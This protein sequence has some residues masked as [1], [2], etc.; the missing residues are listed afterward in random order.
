M[1]LPRRMQQPF[2]RS[3]RQMYKGIVSMKGTFTN[4]VLIASVGTYLEASP[5][6]V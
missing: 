4:L 6:Q 2:F 3:A 5:M 1:S